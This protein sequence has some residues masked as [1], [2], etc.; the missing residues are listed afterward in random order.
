MKPTLYLVGVP[1]AATSAL[2]GCM[3]AHPQIN[4]CSIKE[5]NFHCT[6]FAIAKPKTEQEYLSLF[7][8]DKHT[9]YLLDASILSMHS[10]A[11][12]ASIAS[13][14]P[15]AK[16]VVMLRN[17]AEVMYS[18]HGQMLYTANETIP[19][20]EQ[21]LA[22]ESE[23]KQGRMIPQAGTAKDCPQLLFYRELTDY[24][25]QLERYFKLFHSD[26][27]HI[28]FYEDFKQSP[29]AVF[30]GIIQFL[31]LDNTFQPDFR[32][33]NDST[34]GRKSWKLHYLIKKA[35]AAPAQALLPA[36]L[37]LDLIMFYNRLNNQKQARLPL[38]PD[39]KKAL[40]AEASPGIERL[41]ALLNKDM[42]S[43]YV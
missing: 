22:A 40:I 8:P 30:S 11:A 41:G 15:N 27:I 18:W 9:E 36:Q 32:V 1:K 6:D 28:A 31:E 13:Y 5:P 4:I 24:A 38:D 35:F 29:E 7:D 43:W 10:K 14:A 19:D 2:A 20:F 23:R 16:I 21:A 34:K 17:P 37:R 26:Q 33:S 39:L 12:A 3:G 25:L 42:S